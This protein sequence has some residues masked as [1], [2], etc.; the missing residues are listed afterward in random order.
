M[1]KL[2]MALAVVLVVAVGMASAEGLPNSKVTIQIKDFTIVPY[3]TNLAFT[4]I[5]KQR[6][7]TASGKEVMVNPSLLCGLYTFTKASSKGG[8][9]SVV[10]ADAE[11]KVKVV[12]KDLAGN[13]VATAEPDG[14]GAGITYSR[15][16]QQ[17][18]AKFAGILTAA[19]L[20]DEWVALLLETMDA[21]SFNFAFIDVPQGEFNVEVQVAIS[22]SPTI[23][24][25]SEA[26]ALI[27]QGAVTIEE[28]R[29]IK[30]PTEPYVINP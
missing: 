29:L 13:V 10:S 28:V 15:R 11:I 30:D 21:H 18:S 12:M 8:D 16:F 9:V 7:K 20:E 23:A 26:K 24:G 4:P 19:G 14:A 27:G 1:K 6:I 17:L 3:T 2:A 25:I 22:A 5:L